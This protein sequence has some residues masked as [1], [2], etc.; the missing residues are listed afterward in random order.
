M[1]EIIETVSQNELN[2]EN[3]WFSDNLSLFSGFARPE[4][5]ITRRKTG[6]SQRV[7][8]GDV[9]WTVGKLI[10]PWGKM[11]ASLDAMVHVAEV[12][13]LE[14][15]GR[16]FIA[17]D[18]SLWFPIACV[19]SVLVELKTGTK[20]GGI[21]SLIGNTCCHIGHCLQSI[22][23]LH[24][25]EPLRNWSKEVLNNNDT[26]FI[27]YRLRDGTNCAYMVGKELNE[28]EKVVFR[29]KWV[30][31]R[32]LTERREYVD[33]M[34]LE[35]ALAKMIEICD[36]FVVICSPL[37]FEEGSYTQKELTIAQLYGKNIIYRGCDS[38]DQTQADGKELIG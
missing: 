29:D 26:H 12:V 35:A 34:A 21:S 2:T 23:K 32:R 4:Y 24:S 5:H 20:N 37:Y 9:I 3:Y 38:I 22:R 7:R 11:P 13:E 6:P 18:K 16:K 19:E 8:P 31:P 10:T 14:D 30:L 27:S 28:K 1:A 15:G 36:H 17:S 33:D 25:D